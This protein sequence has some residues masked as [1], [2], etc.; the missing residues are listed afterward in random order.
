MIKL[1][2][3]RVLAVISMIAVAA[4]G[5]AACGDDEEETNGGGGI[6]VMD[7]FGRAALDRGAAYMTI[8]NNGS[9]D[10]ALIAASAPVADRVELHETVTVGAETKMQKVDK[11]EV[12]AG[13]RVQLKPG[14]L[15]VML[16]DLTQE[17]KKGD[18]YTLTLKFESGQTLDVEIV[19]ESLME[20]GMGN[21]GGDGGMGNM[22]ES[23]PMGN[24]G[25]STPMGNMGN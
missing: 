4:V 18:K 10:D 1:K 23:T 16:L 2:F 11:I 3:I 25:N 14:G 22:G 9:E 12:P 21:M 13:E 6:E 19:V 17:L 24:M 5:A 20:D 8:V 7:A 15:H